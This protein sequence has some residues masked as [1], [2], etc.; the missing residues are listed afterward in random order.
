M[1]YL[2]FLLKPFSCFSVI[3]KTMRNILE[4]GNHLWLGFP[5][6]ENF[7]EKCKISLAYSFV[8]RKL[9]RGFSN[10]LPKWIL[11]KEAK[12][13]GNSRGQ[14]EKKIYAQCSLREKS[15]TWYCGANSTC[16]W[17]SCMRVIG[18]KFP[19]NHITPSWWGI[20][21]FLRHT[22]YNWRHLLRA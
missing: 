10:F 22:L 16:S 17:F 13:C 12:K 21:V 15:L 18:N 11:R 20:E 7:C 19:S 3:K 1:I 2:Y 8:F 5:A 14:T 9:I 6:K 4:V